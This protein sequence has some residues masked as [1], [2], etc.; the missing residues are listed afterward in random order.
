MLAEKQR[1]Q[2]EWELQD[3]F[4]WTVSVVD[5]FQQSKWALAEQKLRQFRRHPDYAK[6]VRKVFHT[7]DDLKTTPDGIMLNG[8]LD[9]NL[10]EWL[11]RADQEFIDQIIRNGG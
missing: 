6:A 10:Q 2:R 1:K 7:A 3:K 4:D 8:I 5:C 11:D 9:D